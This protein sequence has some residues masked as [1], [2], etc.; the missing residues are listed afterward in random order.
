MKFQKI[1]PIKMIKIA[2][3]SART[4]RRDQNEEPL[5][6]LPL[7]FSKKITFYFI[8]SNLPCFYDLFDL[9]RM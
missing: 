6:Q 5:Y 7:N 4:F 9:K 3:A 1:F 8:C 2:Q